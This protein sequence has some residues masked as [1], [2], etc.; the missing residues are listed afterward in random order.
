MWGYIDISCDLILNIVVTGGVFCYSHNCF[1]GKFI[2][3]LL[4]CFLFSIAF[5]DFSISHNLVI[6]WVFLVKHLPLIDYQFLG[7]EGI[8]VPLLHCC[9]PRIRTVPGI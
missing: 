3:S 2:R 4:T 7:R 6:Y 5:I 9:V 8:F 1:K